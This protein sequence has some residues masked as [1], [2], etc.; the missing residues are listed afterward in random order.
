[1][2]KPESKFIASARRGDIKTPNTRG[3][4][5]EQWSNSFK[6]LGQDT[7]EEKNLF[8]AGCRVGIELQKAWE[9]MDALELKSKS[10]GQLVSGLMIGASGAYAFYKDSYS[11]NSQGPAF[12]GPQRIDNATHDQR[13]TALG[14]AL[15]RALAYV[16]SMKDEFKGVA[17]ID[18]E[19]CERVL[20]LA[21][22]IYVLE[23]FMDRVLWCDW[24]VVATE[25]LTFA[26]AEAGI[27]FA[28]NEAISQD[29]HDLEYVEYFLEASRAWNEGR[30]QHLAPAHLI[31]KNRT[32]ARTY[33]EFVSKPPQDM[34]IAL[35]ISLADIPGWLEPILNEPVLELSNAS[36]RQLIKAWSLLREAYEL[37]F[38][39]DSSEEDATQTVMLGILR[40]DVMDLLGR[41]GIERNQADA[42]IEFLSYAGGRGDP[43]WRAP[44]VLVDGVL[45]PFLPALLMPNLSRT[46]DFWLEHVHRLT[47]KKKKESLSGVRGIAFE[48][49]VRS[50]LGRL[51]KESNV[52]AQGCVVEENLRLHGHQVDLLMRVGRVVYIGE[53]KSI[54]Y[55]ANP[56]DFGRYFLE[57]DKGAEQALLRC[58]TLSIQKR[59]LARLTGYQGKADELEL[60]PLLIS[61]HI[62]GSGLRFRD[63]PC[64]QFDILALFFAQ[65]EFV[66]FDGEVAEGEREELKVSYKKSVEEFGGSL[67]AFIETPPLIEFRRKALTWIDQSM[68]GMLSDG[69]TL[70]WKERAVKLPEEAASYLAYARS[71][72]SD[73]EGLMDGVIAKSP[74]R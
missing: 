20:D 74:F 6:T 71:F 65:A 5:I 51:M 35:A 2:Q 45:Y 28:D 18:M 29:L 69:L 27:P 40:R 49:H 24:Q 54:K 55:A 67:R 62:L 17:E 34:P 25:P 59:E 23:F 44:L 52:A 64:I 56:P 22:R 12:T 1:M 72:A 73:W 9:R 61:G 11:T 58:Q 26:P 13:L 41:I 36:V 3:F 38:E 4:S 50:R 19:V 66:L 46:I 21:S 57:L 15:S 48:C 8:E 10:F 32:D 39:Q 53:C 7:R 70:A 42:I 68:P 33:F 14:E 43:I 60:C 37:V 30:L 31:L 16:Y 63:V 47:E